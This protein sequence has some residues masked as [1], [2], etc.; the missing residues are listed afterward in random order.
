M[1]LFP[2][3]LLSLLAVALVGVLVVSFL[4]NQT[5]VREVRRFMFAGGLIPEQALAQGLGGYYQG[6]GSW[7]GVQ[8]VLQRRPGRGP[9]GMGMMGG[10]LLVTDAQNH[11]VGDS[12]NLLL[13]QNFTAAAGDAAI[14]IEIEGAQV[15]M[16]ISQGQQMGAGQTSSDQVLA[17]VNRGIWLAAL[18]AGVVALV[19]AGGLAYS[20][21][22]P[23]QQVTE[24]A[25]AVA[26]GDLSRRVAVSAQDE[27]GKL[28]ATF[29]AMAAD[30]EKAER[31]RRDMTA[32]VA[33]ELRNPLAVLQ[34]NLEAVID[35][36]LP[37]APENLLPLLDQ[38]LLLGR[39]VEDLRTLSLAEAGQLHLDRTPT[40]PAALMQSVLTQFGAPAAAKKIALHAEIAGGLAPLSLDPQRMTQVL[41]NLLSNALRH[42]PEGGA[43]T[44]RVTGDEAAITFAVEDTGPGIAP[45]FLPH[46]FERFY[47]ADATRPREA[48]GTGLGLAIAKQL[49]ELH[50]GQIAVTSEVNRGATVS[51]TLPVG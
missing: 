1:R 41:G 8:T 32:D 40:D 47:R 45:E 25:S 19:M 9:F 39:L 4:A 30:L 20:L 16:L 12:A 7:E 33:H 35:G 27:I 34:G 21:V 24:A 36:V 13:G 2:K 51:V 49:V 28:A 42:T 14:P 38:T 48:G 26:R 17:R 18:V 50:G 23:I 43:I 22:R 10:R 31:V 11:V 3:L 37:P 44:G 5:T 46:L 15:G 6:H 29:N